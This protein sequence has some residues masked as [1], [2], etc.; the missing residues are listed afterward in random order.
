ME[1]CRKMDFAGPASILTFRA[2]TAV[3]LAVFACWAGFSG[4]ACAQS[5]SSDA[6][7]SRARDLLAHEQWQ[8]LVDLA[9]SSQ[10]R[11]AELEYLYGTALGR[12]GHWDDAAA[13]FHRGLALAPGDARFLVELAGVKF[14]EKHYSEASALLRQALDI[15]PG[16]TY[17]NEFLGTVYFLE[18]NLEAALKYWNRVGKPEIAS[19]IPEPPPKTAPALLDQTFAFSPASVMTLNELYRSEARIHNLAVFSSSG[20]NLIPRDDS[21]FDVLFRNEEHNGFGSSKLE[22]LLMLLRG[23]PAEEVNPEYFNF[24]HHATN[25]EAFY[26]WDG[27]KR[28]WQGTVSGLV[29]GDPERRYWSGF[30]VRN[31]N[32]DLRTAFRGPADQLGSF[33]MRRE[34]VG[35][36]L[37]SLV[38]GHWSWS[39]GAELSHRDFRSVAPGRAI[40]AAL[41]SPGAQLK[42]ITKLDID[43]WRFPERRMSLKAAVSSEAGRL[44]STPNESFLKTQG[45]A[46][47]HWFPQAEGED[48]EL[49]QRVLTGKTFGDEPI[50]ELF[51]LGVLGDNALQMRGHVTTR[52]GRKGSGPM[53]RNYFVSNSDFD[54]TLFSKWG[55]TAKMGPFLDIGKI[56]DST[57]ALGSHEWLYDV[58]FKVRGS[59]FGMG[60]VFIYGKDLRTGNNAFTVELE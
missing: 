22:V 49:Q 58:G 14:K 24:R 41:L 45:M 47:F 46:R 26:R 50:D 15:S 51:I 12:L 57:P 7:V 42:E 59:L 1:Q 8:L 48:Y 25:F 5:V 4:P 38:G 28:R 52:Q 53:G 29:R 35:A 56:T 54:K 16:D 2:R 17:A 31:E 13:A 18:R 9:A 60:A 23:L 3:I 44:W 39:A 34:A 55:L 32:W 40:T 36:N 37:F 33:N 6:I 11:S 30:D 27:Q 21:K 20:L 19:V 10:P 43:L